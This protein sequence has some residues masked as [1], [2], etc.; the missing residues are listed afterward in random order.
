[1]LIGAEQ[2]NPDSGTTKGRILSSER[3]VRMFHLL[4]T[5]HPFLGFNI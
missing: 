4:V 1:M 5:T 3:E 2:S